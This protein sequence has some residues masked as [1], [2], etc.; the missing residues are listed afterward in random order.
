[1]AEQW[2]NWSGS[3]QFTPEKIVRPTSEA[4][5]QELVRNQARQ[6]RTLRPVGRGH[7]S[8]GI[9]C[10]L[11][12]LLSLEN[13]TGVESV[14]AEAG[15]AWVR[16][17]TM[18]KDMS[19]VLLDEG[20]AVHNLGDVDVQQLGGA[21][22]TGTHGTGRQLGNL[23][24]MLL[25]ARLVTAD[26][27]LIERN[28]EDD[29]EF[30]RALRVSMGVLGV[31]TSLRIK[32]EPRYK[33]HRQEWCTS[34]DACMAHLGELIEQNRNFDFY[35][36][37]RS[38][39]IKLRTHNL[40]GQSPD[41]PY[42]RLLSES[43]DWGPLILSKSRE[44]RFEEMEYALPAAA[45]IAAFLE[46]RRRTLATHRRTVAWR[47]LIRTIA[48]DDAM[49]SPYYQRDSVS[50]SIHQNNT[51]PYWDYFHDIEPVLCAHEGRPHWGKKH[52]LRANQLARL[53]PEWASFARIR[54]QLD[55]RG[56]FMTPYLNELLGAESAQ[57][58]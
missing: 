36:Y 35:W 18:L 10:T 55:P 42:A 6:G 3:Q 50:V 7:S 19:A 56:V 26:G 32:L 13:F 17:G 25:G 15:E 29:P 48:A 41:L 30:I 39:E 20:L 51:L 44:L 4:Q 9:V 8:S 11:D 24:T 1:M 31:F 37:P 5:I 47:T 58:R 46:V 21:I 49:L 54:Q 12:T 38:D 52:T 43:I 23:S 40:P 34:V 2:T 22:G 14:D 53:Y 28:I 16:P 57:N 27:Q 33:L 45:G